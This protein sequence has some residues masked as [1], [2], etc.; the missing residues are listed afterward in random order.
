MYGRSRP[1]SKQPLKRSDENAGVE[2]AFERRD[3]FLRTPG[4]EQ[5]LAERVLHDRLAGIES[6]RFLEMRD[7]RAWLIV[8]DEALR[9]A[10]VDDS[11]RRIRR[12]RLF[13]AF[14]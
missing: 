3:R 8:L 11:G 6:Q 5:R 9:D 2:R 7:R 10:K 1:E 12:L 4:L 13:R 14:G